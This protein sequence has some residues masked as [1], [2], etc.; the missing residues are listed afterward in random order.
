MIINMTDLFTAPVR[1]R[2]T[3][4]MTR[5]YGAD[6]LFCAVC[7]RPLPE[8]RREVGLCECD[9]CLPLVKEA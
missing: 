8:I 5:H 6:N 2:I 7:L 4:A 9:L 1:R 3:D